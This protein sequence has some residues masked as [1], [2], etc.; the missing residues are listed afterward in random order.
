MEEATNPI[1][2]EAPAPRLPTKRLKAQVKGPTTTYTY[3]VTAGKWETFPL[4]DGNGAYQVTVYK[5]IADTKYSTVLS[6]NFKAT[7]K[8]EFAPFLRPNQYVDYGCAVNT[9]AKAQELT[10]DRTEPLEMVKV[11][12]AYLAHSKIAG[13][14][15]TDDESAHAGM[16]F[17]CP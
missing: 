10:K 14:G 16:G 12:S 1:E 5:N 11:V 15:M 3:N 2:A 4:S 9:V 7:L 13:F 8:D 6:A 17:H